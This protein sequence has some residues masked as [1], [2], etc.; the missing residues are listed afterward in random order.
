MA[1]NLLLMI[2]FLPLFGSLF[3]ALSRDNNGTGISVNAAAVAVWTLLFNIALILV[4]FSQM[5]TESDN[6]QYV[7]TFKWLLPQTLS[8]S[9]GVDVFALFK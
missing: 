4:L 5:N 2:I 3:V 9:F 8:I 6:I 7:T 1:E